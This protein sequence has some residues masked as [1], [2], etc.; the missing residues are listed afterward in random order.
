MVL[1]KA[2]VYILGGSEDQAKT[3][4]EYIKGE[5]E[6]Q[7]EAGVS[8]GYKRAPS[9]L[10]K[11][12]T[13]TEVRLH[14]RG[15]AKAI[16]ASQK[17][18]RG[19]H[20]TDLYV[21]ELDECD[22]DVFKS[23][24]GQTYSRGDINTLHFFTSTWQHPDGS[25]TQ[26][27]D[28][29]EHKG[30]GVYTWCYRETHERY[31]GHNTQEEIDR[32]RA[33]MTEADWNTEVEL[34]R[35]ES[36]DLIFSQDIIEFLFDEAMG[37]FTDKIGYE[38]QLIPPNEGDYFYTGADWAKKRDLTVIQTNIDNPTGPDTMAAFLMTQKEPYPVMMGQFND[39][40]RNYGGPAMFDGTGM[41]GD[42]IEDN[43]AVAATPF[44]FSRR[45]QLHQI[46][47]SYINAI[48]KGDYVYPVIPY[49]RKQYSLL[50]RGQVYESTRVSK[51]NHTPDTFVAGALARE[52]QHAGTFELLLG[53][54]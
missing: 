7:I 8:W 30:W 19:K 47:S 32:K 29:A 11:S 9:H 10:L 27:F 22:Y 16:P 26:A 24:L 18:T 15:K 34:Q 38:Y 50:T 14:N 45:N 35:P 46:Y 54:A 37:T 20:G 51:K 13:A 28:E 31:G 33:G 44:D 4:Q 39:R 52:A 43:L 1:W 25:M 36:G 12:I 41:A 3:M 23:A 53:R 5:H 42:M 2:D 48:E 17:A 6:Q 40:I 49:L 21:D